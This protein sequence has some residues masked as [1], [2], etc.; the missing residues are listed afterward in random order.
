M[1]LVPGRWQLNFGLHWLFNILLP[2]ACMFLRSRLSMVCVFPGILAWVTSSQKFLAKVPPGLKEVWHAPQILPIRQFACAEVCGIHAIFRRGLGTFTAH[3]GWLT[4]AQTLP[5][6]PGLQLRCSLYTENTVI[7][8]VPWPPQPS[9]ASIMA[10]PKAAT[11]TWWLK[12]S[13]SLC[14]TA[15]TG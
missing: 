5:G 7:A 2:H 12:T 15:M 9:S 4:M 14:A 3:K 1:F 8:T 10:V 13:C 11:W 6:P